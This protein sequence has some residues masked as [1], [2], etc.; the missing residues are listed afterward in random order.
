MKIIN[1]INLRPYNKKLEEER[2]YNLYDK[3]TN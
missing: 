1:F 3:K 2:E